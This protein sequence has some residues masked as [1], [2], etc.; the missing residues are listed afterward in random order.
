V[1]QALSPVESFLAT[2]LSCDPPPSEYNREVRK[3][4]PIAVLSLLTACTHDIQNKEAVRESIVDYLKV[5]QTQTGLNV[6]MMQVEISNVTFT[7]SGNEAHANVMFTPKAGGQGM[8]M[9]YTLDR[10]GDKWVV[11]PHAEGTQNPHGAAG[12][13]ALP[14]AL[15]PN[16][17]PV[18]KQK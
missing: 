3:L 4:A 6:D 12:L 7:S 17:P 9:P 5:R 1:G 15:P 11:R 2:S 18:E 16:Q 8:T 10:K 13:P 14:P